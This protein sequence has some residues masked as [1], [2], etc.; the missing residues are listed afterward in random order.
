M[1]ASELKS[2]N[3]LSKKSIAENRAS[4]EDISNIVQNIKNNRM[5]FRDID[6]S[7]KFFLY[8]LVLPLTTVLCKP[9]TKKRNVQEKRNLHLFKEA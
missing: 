6:V 9:C 1:D 2:Y 4:Q 8:G 3:Q 5:K 7:K